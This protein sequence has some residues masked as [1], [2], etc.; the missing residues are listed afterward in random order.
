MARRAVFGS[1]RAE[2][3]V[4]ARRHVFLR[5]FYDM[6]GAGIVET[7]YGRA[8][9]GRAISFRNP[10]ETRVSVCLCRMRGRPVLTGLL[11]EFGRIAAMVGCPTR[12]RREC[13]SYDVQTNSR[14][15]AYNSMLI[16]AQNRRDRGERCPARGVMSRWSDG[17]E[18]GS[19]TC[20]HG[21]VW[22]KGVGIARRLV[23]SSVMPARWTYS[24]QSVA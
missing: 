12:A 2:T 20:K 13:L 14:E 16:C 17:V 8:P 19:C 1:P 21:V 11:R 9:V 22:V 3:R 4:S 24:A 6:N 7:M 15:C 18:T 10:T 23:V 5:G